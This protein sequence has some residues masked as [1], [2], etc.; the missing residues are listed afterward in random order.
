MSSAEFQEVPEGVDG[1]CISTIHPYLIV[2]VMKSE[3]ASRIH[4]VLTLRQR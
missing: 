3:I 2:Y 4:S 1:S